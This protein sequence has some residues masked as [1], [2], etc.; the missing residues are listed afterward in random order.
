MATHNGVL[1]VVVGAL[2]YSTRIKDVLACVPKP[3]FLEEGRCCP[4]LLGTNYCADGSVG[5][6]FCAHKS[7]NPTGCQCNGGCRSG[8]W[9]LE[10]FDEYHFSGEKVAIVKGSD[11]NCVTLDQKH[12]RRASSVNTHFNCIRAYSQPD[13]HG[14]HVDL[15]ERPKGTCHHHENLTKCQWNDKIISVGK[16]H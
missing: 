5:T 11:T 4:K 9:Y 15:A 7:C 6:P 16:C 3:T 13:C 2:I 8:G 10:L 12:R 1:M 14:E